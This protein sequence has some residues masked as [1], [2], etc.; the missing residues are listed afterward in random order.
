LLGAR[1]LHP[2]PPIREGAGLLPQ[3]ADSFGM[4]WE[5]SHNHVLPVSLEVKVNFRLSRVDKG[6]GLSYSSH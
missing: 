6:D 5:T 2:V 3:P 1:K 4:G